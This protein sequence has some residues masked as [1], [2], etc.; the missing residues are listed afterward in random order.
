MN[1]VPQSEAIMSKYGEYLK[2]LGMKKNALDDL[3]KAYRIIT[4]EA[5]KSARARA[6]D[7]ALVNE[8][9]NDYMDK[10]VEAKENCRRATK[11]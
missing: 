3:A 6:M 8:A 2:G 11:R 10:E 7:K 4:Q 5:E 9:S 1:T